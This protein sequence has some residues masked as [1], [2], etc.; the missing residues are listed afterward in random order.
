MLFQL[1][2]CQ[3]TENGVKWLILLEHLLVLPFRIRFNVAILW[4]CTHSCLP[5][6]KWDMHLHL[7]TVCGIVMK[8]SSLFILILPNTSLFIPTKY[9]IFIHYI[10][11]LCLSYVFWCYI[12]HH[13]GELMYPLLKN[14]SCY[15]AIVWLLHYLHHKYTGTTFHLLKL[16]YTTVKI[17]YFVLLHYVLK[18]LRICG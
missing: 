17:T 1:H 15:A 13:W 4:L 16:Q 18:T 7:T 8:Y 2:L 14:S 10:H 12:H 3:H 11:L 6:C 5:H 9:T